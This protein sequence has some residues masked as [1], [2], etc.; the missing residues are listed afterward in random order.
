ME[1]VQV[2]DERPDLRPLRGDSG[3]G[4]RDVQVAVEFVVGAPDVIVSPRLGLAAQI[5]KS[6]HGL[7]KPHP[8][9]DSKLHGHVFLW[10]P[11]PPCP[12]STSAHALV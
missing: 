7:E 11:K 2:G 9:T 3:G 1:R 10:M 6:G 12:D 5:D 4:Q 8:N